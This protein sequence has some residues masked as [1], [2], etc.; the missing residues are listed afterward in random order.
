MGP[1]SGSGAEDPAIRR[2]PPASQPN[3]D[4]ISTLHDQTSAW[5]WANVSDVGPSSIRCLDTDPDDQKATLDTVGSLPP[6][7]ILSPGFHGQTFICHQQTLLHGLY[8]KR[9]YYPN[10][11]PAMGH[12]TDGLIGPCFNVGHQPVSWY[13]WKRIGLELAQRLRWWPIFYRA[14]FHCTQPVIL[15]CIEDCHFNKSLPGCYDNMALPHQLQSSS[16]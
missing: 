7:P 15:A 16:K 1:V 4:L 12:H 6:V 14:S 2:T 13:Q 9:R 8:T 3:T 10:N 5:R 11:G